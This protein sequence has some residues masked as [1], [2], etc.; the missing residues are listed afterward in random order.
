MLRAPTPRN[1]T[2][3][4]SSSTLLTNTHARAHAPALSLAVARVDY[5]ATAQLYASKLSQE[6]QAGGACEKNDASSG[7]HRLRKPC[8]T[9]CT[10][11]QHAQCRHHHIWSQCLCVS[12]DGRQWALLRL[13]R[14]WALFRLPLLQM[15]AQLQWLLRRSEE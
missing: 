4:L 1:T 7:Q 5:G 8:R 11:R 14:Q 15:M 3:S 6:P 10:L 13:G 12:H 9:S 2:D